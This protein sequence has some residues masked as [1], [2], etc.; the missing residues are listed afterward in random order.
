MHEQLGEH[1]LWQLP[2]LGPVHADTIITTWIV[3]VIAL[4]LFAVVDRQ[5]RRAVGRYVAAV[6][7]LVVPVV[8]PVALHN[9]SAFIDN[10]VRF[11]LGLAGV[12]SPAASA[13]PGHELVAAFPSAHKA[14]VVVVGVVGIAILIRYLMK[15]PPRNPAD[16]ARLTGWFMLIAILLAPATRVG[17][18]LYPINL[19]VWAWMLRRSDEPGESLVAFPSPTEESLVPTGS[20]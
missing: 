11:P 9:P 2:V 5:Q 18:L 16:V 1:V 19:F 8:F 4:A 17:Y 10:V 14:Y 12:R 15:R 20:P 7:A 13:L 6:A 3:M